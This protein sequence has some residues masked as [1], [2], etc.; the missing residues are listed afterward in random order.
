HTPGSNRCLHPFPT[1][2]S[3]DLLTVAGPCGLRTQ[4]RVTAGACVELFERGVRF[5]EPRAEYSRV[6][7]V[8]EFCVTLNDRSQAKGAHEQERSEEHTSELQSLR[9]LV[10]RP[11]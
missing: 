7:S 4:L 11:L 6:A 2:R 1:R 5:S 8:R 9:Q 10:C 3:S